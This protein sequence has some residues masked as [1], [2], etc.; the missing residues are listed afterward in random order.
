MSE[1][2]G[3]TE[4]ASQAQDVQGHTGQFGDALSQ[5][6]Q[7][8]S[9][10]QMAVRRYR[11]NKMAMAGLLVLI[12]M[13]FM[14]LGAGVIASSITKH[15]PQEQSLLDAFA[16][17][18]ESG[19]L[20]GSDNLGRDTAT[21]LVYGARV[22]LGVAGLAI[23]FAVTIGATVG[24]AAG[25]YGGWVDSVLMRFVDVLLSIPVLFLL[26][27]ITTLWHVGTVLL[28]LVIAAVSWV[29][30]SRLIRGEVISVKNREYVEA[31]RVIGVGDFRV[32]WRHILP[33]VAPVMIVCASL[34]MPALILV[35]AA[36]SYLGL[37]VQPPTPSWG[38]M[39]SDA[40][41]VWAHSA[42]LVIL[43]GLAIYITVFAINLMGN[44]LRDALDP[45][46]TD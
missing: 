1:V 27:L 14:A 9:Y 4:A 19:Y 25:F 2:S 21:R 11:R 15:E 40:R 13:I 42:I 24:L 43:P 17:V 34:T 7:S 26:L 41:L 37:G 30:L 46:V 28:A 20:L 3:R 10:L 29:T 16:G 33:N 38:N 31:A 45:R 5:S 23:I 12:V 39:L 44:G 6:V 36:L 22:S 18:G 32:I 8:R 35:E